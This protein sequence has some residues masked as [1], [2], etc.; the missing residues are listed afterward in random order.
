MTLVV[1]LATLAVHGLLDAL[2]CLSSCTAGDRA[3]L[4]LLWLVPL[5]FGVIAF[6][7]AGRNQDPPTGRSLWPWAV[8]AGLV[9]ISILVASCFAVVWL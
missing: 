3:P 1:G 9:A 5:A 8:S 7:R 2:T 6:R 4:L